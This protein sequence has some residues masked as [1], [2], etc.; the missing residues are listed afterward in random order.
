LISLEFNKANGVPYYRQL[1]GILQQQIQ[2]GAFAVGE[3]LPSE[4]ELS[5][6]Y[7]VNRHTVRQA[8]A[9]LVSR[10]LVYKQKG[11]GTF[12]GPAAG[13]ILNYSYA[14]SHRFTQNILVLGLKPGSRVLEAK[15][16]VATPRVAENLALKASERVIHLEIL[17]LVDELPFCISTVYLPSTQVPGLLEKINGFISLYQLLEEAY[18]LKLVR[19]RSVFHATFPEADDAL[20]LQ[21]PQGQ[22][23]LKVESLAVTSEGVPVEYSISRFRSDRCKI[24]VDFR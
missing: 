16:V 17:R 2:E 14:R 12:V 5:A 3:K 15:E 4:S 19:L 11:K 24:G 13:G 18:G 1:A 7:R 21:I 8:I 22:P 9:E 23:I 6:T 20:I 10:G